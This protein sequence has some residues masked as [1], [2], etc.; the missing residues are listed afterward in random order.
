MIAMAVDFRHSKISSGVVS[1]FSLSPSGIKFGVEKSKEL[2][3]GESP[4]QRSHLPRDA[5]RLFPPLEAGRRTIN[6]QRPINVGYFQHGE[7]TMN[8]VWLY[9]A[10]IIA[11]AGVLIYTVITTVKSTSPPAADLRSAYEKA[12]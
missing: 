10:G 1:I 9:V 6:Q 3:G 7:G 8:K 11:G 2:P 12:K 4:A 5:S